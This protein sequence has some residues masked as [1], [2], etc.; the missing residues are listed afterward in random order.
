MCYILPT[1][2]PAILY[3]PW[4]R[5]AIPVGAIPVRIRRDGEPALRAIHQTFGA[6]VGQAVGY[7]GEGGEGDGH[8]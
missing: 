1:H 6:D 8:S 5:P 2:L 3:E 4:F 7:F